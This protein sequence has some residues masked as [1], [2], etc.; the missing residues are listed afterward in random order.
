MGNISAAPDGTLWFGGYMSGV[1]RFDAEAGDWKPIRT[2]K[3]AGVAAIAAVSDRQAWVI[4]EDKDSRRSVLARVDAGGALDPA[5][6]LPDDESPE[7]VAAAFDGALWTVSEGKRIFAADGGGSSWSEV[8]AD[9]YEIRAIAVCSVSSVWALAKR[10]GEYVVLGRAGVK[11]SWRPDADPG[12]WPFDRIAACADG[13]VWMQWKDGYMVRVPGLEPDDAAS[14]EIYHGPK[15]DGFSLAA[16]SRELAWCLI[17]GAKVAQLSVGILDYTPVPWPYRLEGQRAAYDWISEKLGIIVGGGLRSRYADLNAPFEEYVR[18]ITAMEC[19]SHLDRNDWT[20]VK[21][22]LLLELGYVPSIQALFDRME[23]LTVEIQG[24]NVGTLPAMAK[25]VEIENDKRAKSTIFEVVLLAMFQTAVGMIVGAVGAPYKQ[26][27]QLIAAGLFGA[28]RHHPE[29]EPPDY[30]LPAKYVELADK[31]TE[32]FKSAL[33]E[34]AKTE[35]ALV[36]DWAKLERAGRAN[37]SGEWS[38]PREDTAKLAAHAETA[39][40]RFFLQALMPTKWR[41]VFLCHCYPRDSD[42]LEGKDVPDYARYDENGVHPGWK[43][44]TRHFYF[45][46]E[47]DAPRELNRHESFAPY[48]SRQLF[49]TLEKAGVPKSDIFRG[50]NGWSLS[51]IH[52]MPEA[53][54]RDDYPCCPEK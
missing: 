16:A 41:L 12:G 27:L 23:M 9:G 40:R 14:I 35:T 54:D 15:E 43:V 52:A 31:M 33:A 10:G 36:T 50:E 42:P 47:R 30:A 45:C 18:E 46:N 1:F 49:N 44:K 4:C 24:L 8:P 6:P 29:A 22:Q 13:S 11:G 26:A 5:P 28:V 51:T 19:P 7:W 21:D 39:F 20:L 37:A 48:P 34:L 2:G 53:D 3:G 25:L 17:R 38:W 32:L